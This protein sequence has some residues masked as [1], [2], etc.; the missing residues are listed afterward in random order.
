MNKLGIRLFRKKPARASAELSLGVSQ[1]V[2]DS[3]FTFVK[4][5]KGASAAL[6]E[7]TAV[8]SDAL[9]LIDLEGEMNA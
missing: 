4:N 2:P 6:N 8:I 7:F 5:L 3:G 1:A 9:K